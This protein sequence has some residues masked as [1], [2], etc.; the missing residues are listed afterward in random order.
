MDY[1]LKHFFATL[2]LR[3]LTPAYL[4]GSDNNG[5]YLFNNIRHAFSSWSSANVI[6]ASETYGKYM[7]LPAILYHAAFGNNNYALWALILI[8]LAVS[9]HYFYKLTSLFLNQRLTSLVLSVFALANIT[10]LIILH[11]QPINLYLFFFAFAPMWLYHLHKVLNEPIQTGNILMLL[12]A[13]FLLLPGI[14]NPAQMAIIA[15]L[16]LLIFFFAF[17]GKLLSKQKIIILTLIIGVNMF[18][19]LP[20]AAEFAQIKTI[21]NTTGFQIQTAQSLT[22]DNGNNTSINFY[23]LI[24]GWGYF[25]SWVDGKPVILFSKLF[26]WPL[27][28]VLFIPM[29]LLT[30]L[31]AIKKPDKNELWFMCGFIVVAIL[32]MN[33]T[34]PLGALY[35]LILKIPG[36]FAF[37]STFT[38]FGPVLVALVGILLAFR[39][40]Q[41]KHKMIILIPIAIYL[42]AISLIFFNGLFIRDFIQQ[43]DISEFTVLNKYLPANSRSLVLPLPTYGAYRFR[44]AANGQDQWIAGEVFNNTLGG[45]E[46][47]SVGYGNNSIT[48][49][50]LHDIQRT[51]AS[52]VHLSEDFDANIAD[53]GISDVILDKTFYD[54]FN[55]NYNY[56]DIR[57]ELASR[58]YTKTFESSQFL[59]LTNPK[60]IPRTIDYSGGGMT[61]KQISPEKYEVN[62]R[63]ASTPSQ[64]R[65]FQSYD[66]WR[67][68]SQSSGIP[69]LG[70]L[71][72]RQIEGATH[73]VTSGYANS[74]VISQKDLVKFNKKDIYTSVD[75]STWVKAVIYFKPQAYVDLGLWSSGLS[76]LTLSGYLIYIRKQKNETK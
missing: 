24:G 7:N 76:L 58:G 19:I 33:T 41:F 28:A 42:L 57:Q 74:W 35:T 20:L 56:Q 67:I 47:L 60:Y 2:R 34:T 37:R 54:P 8:L 11:W 31:Y 40:K 22:V 51:D 6:G 69:I 66:S 65:L 61:Y 32:F 10:N 4:L 71:F 38:K 70:Y 44:K 36:F 43:K 75:G 16:S 48:D 25:N 26:E 18:F 17:K 50:F 64:L 3:S 21:Q 27:K 45:K 62:L 29:L 59:I 23:Q 46:V 30:G 52:G 13:N 12:V 55:E 72:S 5:D 73:S 9:I 53:I 49:A 39:A 63:V 68:Y 15:A 14:S 1:S